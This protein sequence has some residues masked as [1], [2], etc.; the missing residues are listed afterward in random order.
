MSYR[1]RIKSKDKLYVLDSRTIRT[2]LS[3]ISN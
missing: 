3:T 2:N 1:Y